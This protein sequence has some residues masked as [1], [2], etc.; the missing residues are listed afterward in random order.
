M[1]DDNDSIHRA[2]R[3]FMCLFASSLLF[4]VSLNYFCT[5]TSLWKVAALQ[6]LSFNPVQTCIWG[7]YHHLSWT[8]AWGLASLPCEALL[9]MNHLHF[10]QKIRTKNLQATCCI[11]SAPVMR[12]ILLWKRVCIHPNEWKHISGNEHNRKLLLLWFCLLTPAMSLC[13]LQVAQHCSR[14]AP[15]VT[16]ACLEHK[17]VNSAG[18]LARARDKFTFA[19]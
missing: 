16:S 19:Q 10:P 15:G 18:I 1:D 6:S 5:F 7:L 14:K 4:R 12:F 11:S 9:P 13:A 2:L 17:W 3:D 8:R